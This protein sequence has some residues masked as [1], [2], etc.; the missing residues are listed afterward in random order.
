[1]NY[2]IYESMKHIFCSFYVELKSS[3]VLGSRNF[4]WSVLYGT[5]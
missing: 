3:Y 5:E 2:E 1:M 4:V